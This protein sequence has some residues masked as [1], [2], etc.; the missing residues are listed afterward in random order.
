MA[1]ETGLS[2]GEIFAA[3]RKKWYI[4]LIATVAIAAVFCLAAVYIYDPLASTYELSF[5]LSYPGSELQ[6]YPDGT[7]FYYRDIISKTNLEEVKRSDGRFARLDIGALFEGD[8]IT[9]AAETLETGGVLAETGRYTLSVKSSYFRSSELA[10]AFLYAVAQSPVSGVIAKA[11]SISFELD[12]VTFREADYED[13]ILLLAQQRENILEQYDEWI[14]LYRVSYTVGSKTLGNYRAEAAVAFSAA[15]QSS[16]LEELDAN[17]YVPVGELD[18]RLK[19]LNAEKA[20]NE[21]KIARL[22]AALSGGVPAFAPVSA[23]ESET[24]GGSGVSGEQPLGLSEMLAALIVRN[25]QIDSQLNALNAE[26]ITAFETRLSDLYAKM[27][28]VA[29]SVRTVGKG[30]FEQASSVKFDTSQVVQRGGISLP[31]GV[32]CG[33]VFGFLLSCV[34]VCVAVIPRRRRA[35]ARGDGQAEETAQDGQAPQETEEQKEQK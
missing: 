18:A 12:E 10:A 22:R 27:A 14:E 28:G 19:A 6:K 33:L 30:L 1:E 2:F 15:L 11:E 26:N 13:R 23:S 34:G 35:A 29:S 31:L 20:E 25:V 3:I 4:V 8:G 21:E 7:P 32:L 24:F 5:L 17:G 16:L 9:I